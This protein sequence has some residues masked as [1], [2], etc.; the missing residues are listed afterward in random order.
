LLKKLHTDPLDSHTN[1]KH[2]SNDLVCSTRVGLH[3]NMHPIELG[4]GNAAFFGQGDKRFPTII[5][6]V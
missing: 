1:T 2:M 5:G 4:G 3:K 6:E